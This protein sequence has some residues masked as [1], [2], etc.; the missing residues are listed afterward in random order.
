MVPRVATLT[1]ALGAIAKAQ[2]AEAVVILRQRKAARERAQSL[3]RLANAFRAASVLIEE[4]LVR[5]Q[6]ELH[7]TQSE[8]EAHAAFLQARV[9]DAEAK[10]AQM[11]ARTTLERAATN[12]ARERSRRARDF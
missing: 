11:Q 12:K 4:P 7:A 3:E 5:K 10:R 2:Q 1:K 8:R 6:F 9:H